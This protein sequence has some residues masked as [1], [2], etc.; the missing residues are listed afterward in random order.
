MNIGARLQA[1]YSQPG[2]RQ[3]LQRVAAAFAADPHEF[4]LALRARYAAD[5]TLGAAAAP[6][7]SPTWINHGGNQTVYARQ[8]VHPRTLAELQSIVAEVSERRGRLKAVGAGH[9]F[10]D[11]VQTDDVLLDTTSLLNPYNHGPLLPL[12]AEL[13]HDPS[14]A[15]QRVRV[16]CGATIRM[17]NPVLARAGLAFSNLGGYDA[18][19]LIGAIATSTHGSGIELPP[20]PDAVRSLVLVTTLGKLYQIEPRAGI[21]DPAKFYRRHR[22]S[23]IEL[24]QDDDW[25]YSVLVSLGCMGVIYSM[26][27]DVLGSYQLRETV[28]RDAWPAV[29]AQLAT[30]DFI[31]AHR[32]IEIQ[33][34]P[35]Y[36][37]EPQRR[38]NVVRRDAV[39]NAAERRDLPPLRRWL[40]AFA[41]TPDAQGLIVRLVND[42]PD[43]VPSLLE[44]GLNQLV[45]DEPH[46]APSY[47]I[48]NLGAVNR[49][50]VTAIEFSFPLQDNVFI[51]AIDR[52]IE[53]MTENRA[54]GFY[55]I[56]PLALRFVRKSRAYL[57][58]MYDRDSCT[59]EVAMLNGVRGG[60]DMLLAYE[61]AMLPF[62]TRPHW[63]QRHELTGTP[64]WLSAHYPMAERWLA[65]H[66]RLNERG[67]FDNHFTDRL[68]ISS[69][70]Q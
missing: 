41:V 9:S 46:L 69:G 48:Y 61:R 11:I 12:E 27:L 35:H 24:I 68:G 51:A 22:Q 2:D 65:L 55:Q 59:C 49:A 28:D 62:R 57:S 45:T 50:F 23:E 63:G 10:S 60:D 37:G 26:T 70:G 53:L 5:P 3:A 39:T 15:A 36:A 25:F 66:A 40:A 31:R 13:W 32:H 33:I 29:R 4:V 47:D 67:I 20:L 16:V 14:A 8:F 17:L 1:L 44:T 56:G 18:Q 43:L 52:L 30:P 19:T 38:C 34:D 42:H 54:R 21:T 7:R 64:G 58:M 6:S